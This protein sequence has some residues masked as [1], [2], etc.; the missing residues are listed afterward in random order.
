MTFEFKERTNLLTTLCVAMLAA[1]TAQQVTPPKIATVPGPTAHR[2]RTMA[3]AVG[4]MLAARTVQTAAVAAVTLVAQTAWKEAAVAAVATLAAPTKN[5]QP[6]LLKGS[7]KRKGPFLV[8]MRIGSVSV[9][10]K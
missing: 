4:A 2:L 6:Y 8:L 10:C 9:S 1:Q 7:S 5:F 3:V